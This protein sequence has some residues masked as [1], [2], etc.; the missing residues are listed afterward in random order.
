[1]CFA[2]IAFETR[3]PKLQSCP[4]QLIKGYGIAN[5]R[6]VMKTFVEKETS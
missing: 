3:L 5:Y 4:F 2:K 1:M 6:L